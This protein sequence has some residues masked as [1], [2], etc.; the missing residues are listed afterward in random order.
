MGRKKRRMHKKAKIWAASAA[1]AVLLAFGGYTV[2]L[3][4]GKLAA[5]AQAEEWR[6]QREAGGADGAAQ[7]G[8]EFG[9]VKDE[10]VY[11]GDT[12]VRNTYM[13]AY[14]FL[15]VDRDPSS[16]VTSTPP[17]RSLSAGKAPRPMDIYPSIPRP[18]QRFVT[19]RLMYSQLRSR[20][21]P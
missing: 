12:Y 8:E 15:G 5:Q 16:T 3:Y 4:Q 6:Q 2:Y 21:S 17:T 1:A 10:I 18:P 11:N 19:A 9:Q 7:A 20:P 13:K 14:L